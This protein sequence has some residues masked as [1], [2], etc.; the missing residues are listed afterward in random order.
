[1]TSHCLRTRV[2]ASLTWMNRDRR[3]FSLILL[4]GLACASCASDSATPGP[5]AAARQDHADRERDSGRDP[6]FVESDVVLVIDRSTF[7]L[8]ASGIDV[9][10]D[11]IVGRNRSWVTEQTTPPSPSRMWTTDSGDTIQIL[12]LEVARALVERLALRNN[13]V[14][15]LSFTLRARL[16]G[17]SLTRLTDK[18]EV[19]VPV[20]PPEAVLASL[21][22]FPAV[23]D[24]RRTDLAELLEHAAELLDEAAADVEPARPRAILLLALG[25]PSAPDG[26]HWSSQ[27]ALALSSEL[28]NKDIAVWAIPFGTADVAFLD[29]LTRGG[30]RVVPLGE[31]DAQFGALGGSGASYEASAPG[32]ATPRSTQSEIEN[33]TMGR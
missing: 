30:G 19:V 11:G 1:M 6:A 17:W 32:G 21:E 16:E 15:L 8:L 5:T 22:N 27:R 10:E 12:Q 20:G 4:L 28:D 7:A 3:A 25:Q 13:R 26:I 9:D 24:R 29:E 2:L 31:L 33:T 14:G 23:R 18:P